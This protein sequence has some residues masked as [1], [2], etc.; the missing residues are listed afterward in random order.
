MGEESKVSVRSIRRE[1]LD[2]AKA[3]QKEGEITEDELKAAEDKIQKLTDNKVAKIDKAI[4]S[5]EKEIMSV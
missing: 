4:E 2:I 5:K 1:G 3:K